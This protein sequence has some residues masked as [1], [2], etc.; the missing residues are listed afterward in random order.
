MDLSYNG[1]KKVNAIL[2]QLQ[3]VYV[4]LKQSFEIFSSPVGSTMKASAAFRVHHT[5]IA[6]Q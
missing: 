2:S 1:M 3:I 5:S 4:T 6:R